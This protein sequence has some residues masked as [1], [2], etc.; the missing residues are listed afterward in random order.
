MASFG[1][2]LIIT[3]SVISKILTEVTNTTNPYR[4]DQMKTRAI[5]IAAIISGRSENV[6]Y[7]IVTIAKDIM[8]STI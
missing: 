5:K 7:I 3:R 2:F 1:R 6:K 4:A 8:N